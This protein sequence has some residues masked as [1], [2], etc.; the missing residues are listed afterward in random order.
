MAVILMIIALVLVFSGLLSIWNVTDI[1]LN[2]IS[3]TKIHL[4]PIL[5]TFPKEW[6]YI[7]LGLVA[8]GI[9]RLINRE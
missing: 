6:V 9:A 7:V 2:F 4:L 8:M 1:G 3:Q 5:S